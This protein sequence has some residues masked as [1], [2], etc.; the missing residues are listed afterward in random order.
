MIE[1]PARHVSDTG[2]VDIDNPWPGL[3]AFR[4]ADRVFFQGRETVIHELSRMVLRARLTIL[5]G[6][7]G[8]GKTSVLRAGLF[9]RLR[10]EHV[11]P[12]YVRLSHAEDAPE[13]VGQLRDAIDSAAEAADVEPPRATDAETLWEYFH[14]KDACFWDIR[15]R[16]VTP[17]LVFDQFEEIFT[18]GRASAERRARTEAFVAEL[19]DLVEGR[20]APHVRARL[21]R[22][23]EQALRFSMTDQP[24]KVL[25]SLRED[26]LPDLAGLR[27]RMPTI[28]DTMYR[29]QP[30]TTVEALRV[31]EVGGGRLVDH[32]VAEQ[33]V[34]FVASAKSDSGTDGE[35]TVVEPA[36]LSVFCRELNHKRRA[37][38]GEKITADL[39]EGSRTA[40][41]SD[42]YERTI[43]EDL[44]PTVR[45][46]VEERLLTESGFRD[47][48]SEEQALRTQGIS[49]ADIERLIARRL[50]RREDAGTRGRSRLE[51]THDVLAEAVRA[52][53][54]RRRLREQERRAL[55]ERRAIE[56]RARREAEE[57]AAREQQRREFE[58]AQ[59]LAAKEREA[60]ELAQALAREEQRGRE[61]AERLA[62]LEH[63]TRKRQIAWL[64]VLLVVISTLASYA[65]RRATWATQA[66]AEAKRT[67]SA[68]QVDRV[69]RGEPSALAFLARAVRNDPNSTMARAL[70]LG[71]L[72]R[73]VIQVAEMAHPAPV[74][75]ASFNAAGSRVLTVSAPA[76]FV[77]LPQQGS[78]RRGTARLWD[79]RA[80]NPL[81]GTMSPEGQITAAVFSPDGTRVLTSSE[82]GVA[83]VWDATTA[84]AAGEPLRHE[85][86]VNAASFD[87]EGSRIVTASNDHSV[88]IWDLKS[89]GHIVIRAADHAI[90]HAS[91]DPTGTRVL[92]ISENGD[93]A[94]WDAR[95]GTELA[96]F[97]RT[98]GDAEAVTNAAFNPDGS[99]VIAVLADGTARLIQTHTGHA[100]DVPLR[101]AGT[102]VSAAFDPQGERVITTSLLLDQNGEHG[103][104]VA[105]AHLWDARTGARFP[106]DLTHQGW[107]SMVG[108]SPDG[109]LIVTASN[110]RTAQVWDAVTG[111]R[112]GA[113]L[114][115]ARSV[116]WA[117]FSPDGGRVLTASEDGTAQLW[118]ARTGFETGAP[119]RHEAAVVSASFSADSASVLTA[120]V[121]GTARVWDARTGVAV[122]T[123]LRH[124]DGF[125]IDLAAFSPD[126]THVVTAGR[127]DPNLVESERSRRIEEVQ[128]ARI[129]DAAT[130]RPVGAG[131]KH[132]GALNSVALS[133]VGAPRIVTAS[134][135]HTA[136][137]WNGRTGEPVGAVMQHG[138]P[139]FSAAFSPDGSRVVTASG[140]GTAR[141][142]DANT[143]QPVSAP[144]QHP[145]A[146]L[147][148]AFSADARQLITGCEDRKARLW[149]AATGEAVAELQGHDEPVNAVAFS[150]D[151]SRIL[152]S[153]DGYSL[154]WDSATRKTVGLRFRHEGA[155][156]PPVFSTRGSEIVT[157]SA[158][159]VAWLWDVRGEPVLRGQLRHQ[160]AVLS[161]AF[162]GDG[163]LVTGSQDGTARIWNV[164]T[165]EEVGVALHH[166]SEVGWTIFATDASRVLTLAADGTARI[167]DVPTGRPEDWSLLAELAEAVGG[168]FVDS[169]GGVNHI[170]DQPK[171][172]AAVKSRGVQAPA[173]EPTAESFIQWLFADPATR[174]I[175]PLSRITVPDYVARLL[176]EGE[177]GRR[178]AMRLFPGHP[179]LATTRPN[180]SHV[181]GRRVVR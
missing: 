100:G 122:A 43:S 88:R 41:I 148:A 49:P 34:R 1:G 5:H 8:L 116:V 129:W 153:S 53:R 65:W 22:D 155:V 44:S 54:D 92:S 146:V 83:Q 2:T 79:P 3:A 167:W 62:Y 28:T 17:L 15:N 105:V 76:Q 126:G 169:D 96:R 171:R 149:T 173:G 52:S 101:E 152:T 71:H 75:R 48:V 10:P 178:D 150:P 45:V 59:A 74:A 27:S 61:A 11:L 25:F 9:P 56:E 39:L 179:A 144:L 156:N 132:A 102:I 163:R 177:S 42:F 120:S 87:R 147:S 38:S 115:H 119:M 46:F 180:A 47:S 80:P 159:A 128:V 7:S 84:R 67:L 94:V 136:R 40:I 58:A 57:A 104:S 175:S 82:E 125:R 29:L 135:D 91:F 181:A 164:R 21:E 70:L 72:S 118:D 50:L 64:A 161:A 51:L 35:A 20:P 30:M 176:A 112:V 162:S 154:L 78:L 77:A 36:L 90:V 95:S 13:L 4:E 166:E 89:G 110:D 138:A 98:R 157:T 143:G 137:L 16:I 33:I 23:P 18:L 24:C 32:N 93:A 68:A 114:Q 69:R 97:E 109:A 106:A 37:Q 172:L 165:R 86:A 113:P 134:D 158:D 117:G 85:G 121:D 160:A 31:V 145:G 123:R 19:S 26:F 12:I 103:S 66:E 139:V 127:L 142:W 111:Q 151:G 124:A 6:I 55:A 170:E 60:A 141:V 107:I 133:P 81:I 140:D 108:F 63:R 168:H 174:T 130:G 73:Q 131:L 99:R 14:R